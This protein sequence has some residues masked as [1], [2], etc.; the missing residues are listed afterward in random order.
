MEKVVDFSFTLLSCFLRQ[1]LCSDSAQKISPI[2]NHLSYVYNLVLLY[3]S[4]GCIYTIRLYFG[5]E[6]A[7]HDNFMGGWI[8]TGDACETIFVYKIVAAVVTYHLGVMGAITVASLKN[9][10]QF[11]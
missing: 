10:A 2:M 11:A 8:C 6:G 9:S 4:V 7:N 3:I 5:P 1:C